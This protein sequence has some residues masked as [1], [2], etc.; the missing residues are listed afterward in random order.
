M[1]A[2]LLRD[3]IDIPKKVFAG[4]FVLRLS[5]GVA[6]AEETLHNYVVTP[7]LAQCFDEALGVI[8]GAITGGKSAACYLHGSF[9]SGKSHFMAVL[10]LLLAGHPKARAIPE[11]AAVVARHNSW[12]EGRRFL[13]VTYHMI[14]ATEVESAI[15]GGYGRQVRA[16]HPDA[17]V[18]GFYLGERLF[19]DARRLRATMGDAAFFAKLNEG[20]GDE[21]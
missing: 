10:N 18:P 2:P 7:Q 11:L 8:G 17:P 4:D 12:T 16:L 15:L 3:L 19:D 6:N 14:G 5:E 21:G 20:G 13:M 9:G 1:S